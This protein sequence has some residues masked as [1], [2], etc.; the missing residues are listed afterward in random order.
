MRIEANGITNFDISAANMTGFITTEQRNDFASGNLFKYIFG[1]KP[2]PQSDHP[3]LMN[4]LTTIEKTRPEFL[5]SMLENG[6]T[7][8]QIEAIYETGIAPSE[9]DF[10]LYPPI[11]LQLWLQ[12]A[13]SNREKTSKVETRLSPRVT[14]HPYG[15]ALTIIYGEINNTIM[16]LSH[17]IDTS[18]HL[19]GN[20]AINDLL[21]YYVSRTIQ[22]IRAIRVLINNDEGGIIVSLGRN[23]FECFV[24]IKFLNER[25]DIAKI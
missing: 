15:I 3:F 14:K 18:F 16:R 21:L 13:N 25:P 24:H 5:E 8:G 11:L 6:M 10:H 7:G 23:L 4:Y 17:V 12:I 9:T 19:P 22:I 1:R 20:D 2:N